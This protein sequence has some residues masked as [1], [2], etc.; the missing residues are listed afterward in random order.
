[1]S[2]LGLSRTLGAGQPNI[3]ENV[4]D[5]SVI[6]DTT[7]LRRDRKLTQRTLF[8]F[9]TAAARQLIGRTKRT[10]D[11]VTNTADCIPWGDH[12]VSGNGVEAAG[13]FRILSHNVNGFSKAN[14]HADVVDFARAI[15][16]KNIGLFGIQETN[17]NFENGHM[18][19]SFHALI[20]G[21]SSHHHGIVSSAKLGLKSDHQ[22]GGTAVSARNKWA[23]RFLAK[24]SDDMGRWSWIT[25]TGQGTIKITFISGYRVCDGAPESS[26]TARMDV[27]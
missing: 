20:R 4:D 14:N 23:T 16:D 18:L 22:P 15:H 17:C 25:L 9:G 11:Y 5:I 24:G 13:F 26:I 1:M 21:V 2:P 19:E 3:P 27:R 12:Q 8:Q 6:R 10:Q 7:S